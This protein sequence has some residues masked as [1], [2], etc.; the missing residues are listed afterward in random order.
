MPSHPPPSTH[1]FKIVAGRNPFL[2]LQSLQFVHYTLL[3][4]STS[5]LSFDD[6]LPSCCVINALLWNIAPPSDE[7]A[8]VWIF[9]HMLKVVHTHLS[10]DM[11][12]VA[13]AVTIPIKK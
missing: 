13:D 1:P 4:S 9:F 3:G 7:L 5:H 10:F 6:F 8:K 11:S 2:R 12:K